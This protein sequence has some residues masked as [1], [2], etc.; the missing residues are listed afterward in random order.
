MDGTLNTNIITNKTMM[1]VMIEWWDE[2]HDES[3]DYD[4]SFDDN[5]H[6]NDEHLGIDECKYIH[7][8]MFHM[9]MDNVVIDPYHHDYLVS[10]GYQPINPQMAHH[11]WGQ[12]VNSIIGMTCCSSFKCEHMD[13]EHMVELSIMNLWAIALKHGGVYIKQ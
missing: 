10:H 6:I 12:L 5:D 8:F 3:L 2:M 13:D 11:V 4:S 9:D 7:Q 1:D